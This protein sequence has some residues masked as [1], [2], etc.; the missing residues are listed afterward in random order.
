MDR[1]DRRAFVSSLTLALLAS[2]AAAQPSRVPPRIGWISEEPLP[3]PFL[4][5][6]LEGLRKL[7]YVEGQNVVVDV[8]SGTR[9]SLRAAIA[10]LV[11]SN[12]VFIVA[13]GPAIQAIKA[14]TGVQVLF[15]ISGDPVELGIA[16]SVARP[17]GT[18][19]GITFL[20]LEV[21]GKRVDLLK[22]A[23]PQIRTLAALANVNHPGE[24]SER[25]ATERAARSLGV[26]MKHAPFGTLAELD[27]ALGAVRDARADAMVVFPDGP[28]MLARAKIAQYAV[29]HRLPTMFGWSEFCDA[30]GLMSYGANQR[31]TYV[32][33]ASHA[34]KLLRGA[35]PADLPIE[36]PTRF[37]LVI[38]LATAKL[39]GLTIPQSLALRA[40]RVIE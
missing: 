14:V 27:A 20:S 18:F 6:F 34:D 38:N 35:K 32:R 31:E 29:A 28:T 25:G 5:G 30:G 39:L 23:V 15:A 22:Q 7:G 19:T 36:Q 13:R 33:L 26:A 21:A 9:E 37:E 8:R 4:D 17:G 24:L 11:R 16:K 2:P 1:L 10:D 3:D 12:V 40:D